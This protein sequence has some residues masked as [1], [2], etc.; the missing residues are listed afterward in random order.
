M[1]SPRIEQLVGPYPT[2]VV[3]PPWPIHIGQYRTF[4]GELSERSEPYE[5]MSLDEIAALPIG[6]ILEPDAN[7]FLWTI[8]RY[9]PVAFNILA[10]WGLRYRFTMVWHKNRGSQFHNGPSS[11]IEFVIVGGKGRSLWQDT[12]DFPMV[13]TADTGEHSVKPELFYSLLRRVTRSPRLDMFNRRGIAGF[14]RW[15]LEAPINE[16]YQ[17]PMEG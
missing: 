10:G 13:F 17:I 4:R 5:M 12:C 7:V 2:V 15:G 1:A 11:N 14:D 8:Q 6:D 16:I 3:D 9:M